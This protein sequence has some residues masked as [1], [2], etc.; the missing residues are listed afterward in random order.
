MNVYQLSKSCLHWKNKYVLVLRLCRPRWCTGSVLAIGTKICGFKPG[1]GRST[2]FGREVQP[3]PPCRKILWHVKNPFEVLTTLLRKTK[4]IIS[5]V[6]SSW[7]S[8]RW[9]L[10]GLKDSFG[11]RIKSFSLSVPFHHGCPCPY[12]TWGWITGPLVAAVLRCSLTPSTWS[13]SL[14][15]IVLGFVPLIYRKRF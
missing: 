12:T 13:S 11:G 8:T 9:L 5:L 10:V 15:P 1:C 4:L 3:S 7:L 14:C 2:S 6:S